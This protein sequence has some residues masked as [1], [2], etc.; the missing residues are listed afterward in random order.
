MSGINFKSFFNPSRSTLQL[1]FPHNLTRPEAIEKFCCS[2]LNEDALKTRF[3]IFTWAA[4]TAER[5]VSLQRLEDRDKKWRDEIRPNPAQ[6]PDAEETFLRTCTSSGYLLHPPRSLFRVPGPSRN[7]TWRSGRSIQQ[8]AAGLISKK[9]T[10]TSMTNPVPIRDQ[11]P[12][13]LATF[14]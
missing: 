3:G 12:Q 7:A 5:E 9:L 8:Q 4:M 10:W 2:P 14:S 11:N 1:P 13:I 6:L